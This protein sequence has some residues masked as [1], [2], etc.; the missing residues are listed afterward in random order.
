MSWFPKDKI[1]VPI[2]F[3]S[4]SER[5][6][7][8]ALDLSSK[9]EGVHVI[10]VRPSLNSYSPTGVWDDEETEKRIVEK[11]E[12]HLSVFLASHDIKRVKSKVLEGQAANR[13]VEYADEIKADL[14]VI[15][16]HGFHGIKRA[17]LGSVAERVIRHA[18][19]ETLVLRRRDAD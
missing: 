1:V 12:E 17:V 9:D 19:V 14:I 11:A 5:A 10:Y 7:N 3:S 13:I 15:P 16:T 6:V 2:D 18:N 8:V 4:S